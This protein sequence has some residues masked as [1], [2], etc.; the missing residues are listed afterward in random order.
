MKN[1]HELLQRTEPFP[2]AETSAA[3]SQGQLDP[4]RVIEIFSRRKE[5]LFSIEKDISAALYDAIRAKVEYENTVMLAMI[6]DDA[7][8]TETRRRLNTTLKAE[9]FAKKPLDADLV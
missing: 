5:M 8:A 6:E 9:Y 7:Q 2:G 1:A 4:T 3:H